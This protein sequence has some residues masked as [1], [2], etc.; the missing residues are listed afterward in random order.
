ML[1]AEYLAKEYIEEQKITTSEENEKL[2]N[3]FK[4]LNKYCIKATNCNIFI[5]IMI[6][7]VIFSAL[8]LIF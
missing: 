7:V 8:S 5:N 3:G 6:K 2:V 1:K 4:E